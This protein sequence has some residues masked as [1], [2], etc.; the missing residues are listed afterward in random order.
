M[1]SKE[2]HVNR[3]S[4]LKMHN[5]ACKLFLNFKT[6]LYAS[7]LVIKLCFK[8]NYYHEAKG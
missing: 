3:D 2:S 8:Q 5:N 1:I 4:S 7:A 6:A